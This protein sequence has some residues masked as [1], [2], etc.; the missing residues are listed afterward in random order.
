M[1][2]CFDGFLM[3]G[4]VCEVVVLIGGRLSLFELDLDFS[5]ILLNIEL[6]GCFYLIIRIEGVDGFK[7][8]FIWLQQ[9]FE[10]GGVNSV[11]EVVDV[12]NL[13]M[14]EQ[15]QF[16]YVFDVDVLE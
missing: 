7:F 2:N 5:I 16:F 3:V 9:C 8:L 14:L 13:V 15:G 11:N 6:D 10:C 4:I 12:I 1:V